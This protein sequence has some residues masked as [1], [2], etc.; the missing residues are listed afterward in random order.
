MVG[1]APAIANAIF[2]AAGVRLRALPLVPNG[3]KA[4]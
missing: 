2:D 3:L 1:L 4:S